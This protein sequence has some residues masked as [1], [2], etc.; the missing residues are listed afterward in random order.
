M[1]DMANSRATISVA[2]RYN[3]CSTMQ[4]GPDA[5]NDAGREETRRPGLAVGPADHGAARSL[6][7]A[8]DIADPLGIARAGSDIAQS[9]R[10][11]RRSLAHRASGAA[12]GTARGRPRRARR[13]RR[14]RPDA[15][16]AGATR[17]LPAAASL[18]R[19]LEQAAGEL[20]FT[21]PP[22]SEWRHWP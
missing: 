7:A 16:G 3:I 11:L 6:G 21:P 9:A 10:G 20:N 22:P 2:A 15:A 17:T 5:E 14:L 1:R 4:E 18:R 8:L 12:I 19:A 13:G